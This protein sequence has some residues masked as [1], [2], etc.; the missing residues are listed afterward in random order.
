[1]AGFAGIAGLRM[2]G[3][4]AHRG[5]CPRFMTGNTTR[6][7]AGVIDHHRTGK[8]RRWLAMAIV[9]HVR[10]R[11][12]QG[13]LGAADPARGM[14]VDAL[15]GHYLAMIDREGTERRRWNAMTGLANI[16]GLRMGRRLADG[17]QR[18][19]LMTGNTTRDDASVIDHHRTGKG[20]RWLAMAIIAH[21][22]G[23]R[24]QGALGAADAARGVT[25][26]AL[27]GHHLGVID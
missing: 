7:D 26:D 13:A 8:G 6:D 5:R 9:A 18:A 23:R 24:M 20:R 27:A 11:R 3:R 25:V 10:G 2:G 4:F 1:M 12:M 17:R 21:V 19:R 16:T 14:A 15:A 22:R